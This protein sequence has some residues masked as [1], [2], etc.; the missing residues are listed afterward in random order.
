MKTINTILATLAAL[1]LTAI[2]A[3]AEPKLTVEAL[4]QFPAAQA[5]VRTT[6]MAELPKK[7]NLFAFSD[8]Y[9]KSSD[10]FYSEA[11]VGKEIAKGFGAKLEWNGGTG[12]DDVLRLGPD[13]TTVIGDKVFLNVKLYPLT[14]GKD[15]IQKTSQLS[16]FGRADLPA[17]VFVENWTDLD[18]SYNG[19]PKL[20]IASETTVG[21]SLTDK[22]ALEGQ[23]GFN[24]GTPGPQGRVGVRYNF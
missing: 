19:K 5:V 17:G 15:G 22:L 4:G 13:Y 11:N 7:V 2:P 3:K 8:F 1:A 9:G 16:F 24:A 12:V 14:L 20:T 21:K 23:F 10:A 18:V 6:V